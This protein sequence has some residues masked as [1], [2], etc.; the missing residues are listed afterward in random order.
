MFIPPFTALRNRYLLLSDALLLLLSVG[1]A[2]TLRFEGLQ[3]GPDHVRTALAYTLL[4]VPLRLSVFFW[5]G[6]YRRLWRHAGV[7]ELEQI[8]EGTAF[9]GAVC[10][11]LGAVLLPWSGL[12]PVRVP[13]SVLLLDAMFTTAFVALPRMMM[14]IRGRRKRFVT[15]DEVR[16]V[17]I[18]GAGR[19]GGHDRPGAA[20]PS[21]AG[22]GACR[23]R[24]RRSAET[25]PPAEQSP[26]A[27]AVSR[28]SP[29]SRA[30]TG[31]TR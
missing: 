4:S 20:V 10:F 8:L 1:L 3:W 21:A 5:F 26:G 28:T 6:F 18:A 14:R 16:R 13:Y 24:G 11:I 29:P 15:A 17:L 19:L 23:L 25:P 2:Y 12:T 27:S 22:P 9:S 30:G 31:S 7:L